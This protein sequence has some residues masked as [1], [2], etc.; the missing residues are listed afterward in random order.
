MAN[1]TDLELINRFDLFPAEQSQLSV[2]VS[3]VRWGLA[4]VAAAAK[5]IKTWIRIQMMSIA[6]GVLRTRRLARAALQLV[7]AYATMAARG[8][9]PTIS[10]A[11]R[12]SGPTIRMVYWLT[13]PADRPTNLS[14]EQPTERPDG[15]AGGDQEAAGSKDG[16]AGGGA[17]A[18]GRGFFEDRSHWFRGCPLQ[19]CLAHN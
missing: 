16:A 12:H 5:K 8:H 18:S 2:L 17:E 13:D 10:I 19:G 1:R 15:A 6:Q 3:R 9:S 7:C 14:A 11:D 4:L